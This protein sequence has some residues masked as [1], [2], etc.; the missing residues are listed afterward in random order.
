MPGGA[1]HQGPGGAADPALVI[2][3]CPGCTF[4]VTRA[5]LE[6]SPR[7]ELER[8]YSALLQHMQHTVG[9]YR[10]VR[11]P[12]PCTIASPRIQ[13][14]VAVLRRGPLSGMPCLLYTSDAADE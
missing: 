13:R 11:C 6:G 3:S 9:Q 10:E 14:I 1:P 8:I 2:T 5:M 12:H 4:T 7:L